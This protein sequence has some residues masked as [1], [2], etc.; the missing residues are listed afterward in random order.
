MGLL[1]DKIAEFN[2][3]FKA[4]LT[5]KG[6]PP[7]NPVYIPFSSPNLNYM[8]YGGLARGIIAEFYGL[9]SGGKTTTCLDAIANAQP[10]FS[11]EYTNELQRLNERSKK[12]PSKLLTQQIEE[13]KERGAQKVVYFDLE[14]TLKDQWALS[15]G[16]DVKNMYV[17]RPQGQSAE[18]LLT[19]AK[20]YL[21]TGGVGLMVIDSVPA[22]ESSSEQERAY[23]E[24]TMGGGGVPKL[25]GRFCREIIPY[26][27]KYQSTLIFINQVRDSMNAYGDPHSTPGGKAIKFY[28]ALRLQFQKGALIDEDGKEL[29]RGT[30][31]AVGNIVD[32]TLKK[33][34]VNRPN[35]EVG[36]YT[37]SYFD[38]ILK[39]LDMINLLIYLNL[40]SQAGSFY[41]FV[42]EDGEPFL[43]DAGKPIK[44]QGKDK[45]VDL[46]NSNENMLAYYKKVMDEYIKN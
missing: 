3:R 13:L 40:I 24:Q 16:V 11:K 14:G 32:I 8:L 15:L 36:Y 2:N 28:A 22:L 41:T 35:R 1:D 18:E 39:D 31:H 5:T 33:N 27:N 30:N 4:D 25:L 38:G 17:I 37:L 23:D 45:L 21:S 19:M 20:E 7:S 6:I 9:E 42:N 34:K 10:L 29:K 26:L 12:S 43:D 46:L 44:A